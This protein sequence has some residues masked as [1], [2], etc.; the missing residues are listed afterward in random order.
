MGANHKLNVHELIVEHLRPAVLTKLD[1][2]LP[3]GTTLLVMVVITECPPKK[4]ST[5]W[6]STN[7]LR[8]KLVALLTATS[9]TSSVRAPR[10]ERLAGTSAKP[11]TQ[12]VVPLALKLQPDR[13]DTFLP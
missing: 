10:V 8:S 3:V 13:T 12:P 5:I 1:E 6:P 9:D 4:V 11:R 2:I 7:T